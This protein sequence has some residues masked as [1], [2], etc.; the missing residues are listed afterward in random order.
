VWAG[1]EYGT[2]LVGEFKPEEFAAL[3]QA[4]KDR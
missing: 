1:P 3:R 4:S 2:V